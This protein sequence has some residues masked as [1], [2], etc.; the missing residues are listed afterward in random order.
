M[1]EST[2]NDT[3]MTLAVLNPDGPVDGVPEWSKTS[4]NGTMID[5][6]E[7]LD[8]EAQDLWDPSLPE[9]YQMYLVSETLPDTEAGPVDTVYVVE[10]DVQ[11]GAGAVH[12]SET[13]TLHVVNRA[14]T[15]GASF[16]NAV[17][18]P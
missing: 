12:V 1:A 13:F 10:A 17:Q 11:M 5:S 15:L 2:I 3:Q 7:G 6:P 4:G 8:Q 18:K 9:G 16:K 14:T